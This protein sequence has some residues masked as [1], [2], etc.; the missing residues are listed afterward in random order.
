MDKITTK[1]EAIEILKTIQGHYSQM[2][3]GDNR[4]ILN[5]HEVNRIAYAINDII[6]LL[7]EKSE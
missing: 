3:K 1:D 2:L 5:C 7:K 6:D 4:V